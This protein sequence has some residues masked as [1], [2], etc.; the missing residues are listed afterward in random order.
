MLLSP[1]LLGTTTEVNKMVHP[2]KMKIDLLMRVPVMEKLLLMIPS[3]KAEMQV[4][5]HLNQ[6]F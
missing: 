4:I 5:I 1:I 6:G 2:Q 3:K